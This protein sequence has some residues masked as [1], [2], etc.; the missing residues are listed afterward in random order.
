MR[1]EIM[2]P[3][4]RAELRLLEDEL[5]RKLDEAKR[6]QQRELDD[7]KRTFRRDFD[8]KL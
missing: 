2:G 5:D 8:A 7:K 4:L 6:D 3:K 1:T